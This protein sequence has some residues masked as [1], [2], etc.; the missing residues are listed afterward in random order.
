MLDAARLYAEAEQARVRSEMARSRLLVARAS[1]RELRIRS[2]TAKTPLPTIS[3]HAGS[4]R[5]SPGRAGQAS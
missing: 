3:R 2:S 4:S 5:L 1:L